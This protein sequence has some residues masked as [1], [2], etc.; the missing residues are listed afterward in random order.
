MTENT[1]YAVGRTL[2][3]GFKSFLVF[4]AVA[5]AIAFVTGPDQASMAFL[6]LAPAIL[7]IVSMAVYYKAVESK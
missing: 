5:I 7:S 1:N 3:W 6:L 4:L 2:D